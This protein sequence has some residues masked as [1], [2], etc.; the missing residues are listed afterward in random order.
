MRLLHDRPRVALAIY[1]HPDDADV[2]AGGTLARWSSLGCAVHLVVAC[3][4]DKGTH[5]SHEGGHD[6][7][8]RRSAEVERAGAHLGLTSVDLLGVPDGEV[9]NDLDLRRRLVGLIRRFRPDV[10]LGPDPSAVFFGGVYVNHRDHRETGGALL[11]AVAPAAAMPLYFPETGPAHAVRYLLL[12][13]THEPAAA[14]DVTASIEAK[15]AAVL[16]HRSKMGG[17][18]AEI[19]EVVRA[20]AAQGAR[21]LGV[22][23]VETFRRVQFT[24]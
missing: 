24:E 13:G 18:T 22:G 17:E 15:V 21:D 11:D 10:V 9:V 7:V 1:A 19:G 3:Q 5:H 20:R 4:G 14:V 8:T 16:E 6:L 12:S 23:F 2:A